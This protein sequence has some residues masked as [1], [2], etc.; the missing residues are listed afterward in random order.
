MID[1][2]VSQI[3][4]VFKLLT[5]TIPRYTDS[6]SRDAVE[7]IGMELVR[8]DELRVT[9]QGKSKLGVTEQILGWLSIEVGTVS[10]RSNAEYV[11]VKFWIVI[12]HWH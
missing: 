6:G 5:L 11:L 4:D 12:I 9:E 1:L 8:R 2:S 3:L 10:K 7:A